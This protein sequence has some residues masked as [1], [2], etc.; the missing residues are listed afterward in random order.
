M[1]ITRLRRVLESVQAIGAD[2]A[3]LEGAGGL[4]KVE[5]EEDSASTV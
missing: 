5:F 2:A 4:M 1:D 3:G